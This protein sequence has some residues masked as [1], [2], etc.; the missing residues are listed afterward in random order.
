MNN[1]ADLYE[2]TTAGTD[3]PATQSSKPGPADTK[4]RIA[5]AVAFV[6]A[7]VLLVVLAVWLQPWATTSVDRAD[8]NT[9]GADHAAHDTK[10]TDAESSHAGHS[11]GG[12]DSHSDMVHLTDGELIAANVRTVVAEVRPIRQDLKV[13]AGV[14][15]NEATH[16][17]VT[18]RVAGRIERLYVDRTGEY[19]RR[20]A[21][22]MEIYSPELI[23]AQRD[24]LIARESTEI[25][26]T[27]LSGNDTLMK[28]RR[29]ERDRR[30]VTSSRTRLR[31]LGMSEAQIVAL[32]RKGEI[33]YT[34]TLFSPASG[35]VIKRAITQGAYV[36]VGTLLLD[37]VDLS[38]VWVLANVYETD[39][40]RVKPGMPMTV[41]GA[42]MGGTSLAGRVE[43]IYPSVD[44]QSRTVKVRG[45]FANPGGLLRPG[46]YVDAAIG[47]PVAS[48]LAVPVDA[49]VRTGRREVVY[50]QVRPNQFEARMVEVGAGD[51]EY[52]Q[53][54]GGDLH[55]GDRVV[56]DGGFLVDSEMRL[57]SG[58]A[59]PHAGHGTGGKGK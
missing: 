5:P 50:V 47:I 36:E 59:D 11:A 3:L 18:A 21:P 17:V 51:G 27:S 42:T 6:L 38:T 10:R 22:L 29:V 28:T 1:I 26:I 15:Y 14:D 40:Y 45:V 43:F 53:I 25:E 37:L 32:E 58:A 7:G 30:L 12:D 34:T 20:G 31:L 54:V 56:A 35:V 8:Q 24:Y 44:Q 2:P 52:L 48:G 16:T 46:M 33:S 13:S 49:V 4:R 55:S 57:N 23:N 19:I 41:S 39:V 9:N